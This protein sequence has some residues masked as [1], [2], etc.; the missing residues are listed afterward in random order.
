MDELPFSLLPHPLAVKGTLKPAG[1]VYGALTSV[2]A[3]PAAGVYAED[4]CTWLNGLW[5]VILVPTALCA[6]ARR[7]HWRRLALQVVAV[8]AVFPW[9]SLW[10][11]QFKQAYRHS[12]GSQTALKTMDK[13]TKVRLL[14]LAVWDANYLLDQ[15]NAPDPAEPV[16]L[17][18]R[19]YE[20]LSARLAGFNLPPLSAEQDRTLDRKYLPGE[21]VRVV[22]TAKAALA[23]TSRPKVTPQQPNPRA[24][25]D[26]GRALGSHLLRC[27]PGA[28]H[29]ERWA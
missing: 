26:A 8:L 3:Q 1:A 20:S 28:T 14:Q 29:R 24:G 19:V 2:C 17:M 10:M 22:R 27:C 5:T 21:L 16:R 4:P 12:A 13:D 23:L 6:L 18:S 15:T 7:L 11:S 25:V 9:A